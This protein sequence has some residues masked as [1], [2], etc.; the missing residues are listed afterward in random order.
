VPRDFVAGS[1][2]FISS[3]VGWILGNAPSNEGGS[4]GLLST[5][6]GTA[7]GLVGVW[8]THD[9]G[10][11][12]EQIHFAGISSPNVSDLV[13]SDG[14]VSASVL[15][16]PTTIE[17]SP[18]NKDMWRTALT[19]PSGAGGDPIVQFVTAGSSGWVIDQDRVS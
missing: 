4:L 17:V 19:L 5:S 14:L 6:N 10:R 18:S 16:I 8:A 9:G 12:W 2:S 15:A 7:G 13:A 1:V 11:L 3:E